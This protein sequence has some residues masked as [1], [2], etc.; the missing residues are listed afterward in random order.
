MVVEGPVCHSSR[1]NEIGSPANLRFPIRTKLR[2]EN[3]LN[4][5]DDYRVAVIILHYRWTRI[6]LLL[7][8]YVVGVYVSVTRHTSPPQSS[9]IRCRPPHPGGARNASRSR[10][11]GPGGQSWCGNA[12]GEVAGRRSR[13]LQATFRRQFLRR[14]P[15]RHQ[16]FQSSSNKFRQGRHQHSTGNFEWHPHYT[17]SLGAPNSDP[18]FCF[19]DRATAPKTHRLSRRGLTRQKC[20]RAGRLLGTCA[21]FLSGTPPRGEPEI[22]AKKAGEA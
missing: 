11:A 8:R 5:R 19:H 3:I 18:P 13:P 21:R 1:R 20:S 14:E 2:H 7:S 9:S 16:I 6:F 15:R 10:G 4:L 17:T 12:R 22:V